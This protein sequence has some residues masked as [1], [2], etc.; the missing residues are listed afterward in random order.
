MSALFGLGILALSTIIVVWFFDFVNGFHDSANSIATIVATKV[1]TPIQAVGMAAVFNF[2]G[3]IMGGAVAATI[4]KNIIHTQI[5][6][7]FGLPLVLSALLGAV[8]WDLI[9]WWLGIPTSSSHALVGGLLGA[10]GA[11]AGLGAVNWT[12]TGKTLVFMVVSP[13]VGLVAWLPSSR[14]P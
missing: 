12:G 13:I 3:I 2:I 8:I 1:L 6:A 4:Q 5:I 10:G 14:G 9:T 11:V 7:E